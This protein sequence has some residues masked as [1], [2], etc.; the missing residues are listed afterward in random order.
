MIGTPT[1]V[2]T[3]VRFLHPEKGT[4]LLRLGASGADVAE[5]IAR[6]LG[7]SS[8]D[9]AARRASLVELREVAARAILDRPGM[10]R[11]IT[12]LPFAQGDVIVALGDSL[13]ADLLSWAYQLE[14]LLGVVLPGRELRVVNH[15]N[16]GDTTADVIERL[17]LV[18]AERPAWVLQLLGTN[19]ARRHGRGAHRVFTRAAIAGNLAT[20]DAIL[21]T[22][23]SA[24]VVRMTPPPIV[25]ADIA[26]WAEFDQQRISWRADDVRDIRDD[27]VAVDPAAIDLYSAIPESML[28][29]DG[30][31]LA[32]EG[33]QAVAEMLIRTLAGG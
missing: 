19:D 1:R 3:A 30:L 25:E 9:L 18:V 12:A 15:G 29:P 33:Q 21:G 13:T 6:D 4:D 14:Y 7:I 17:D 8:L 20:I 22:E 10:E 5:L 24:R 27:L 16:S 28:G 2:E 26:A 32:L 31:H 23:T 11:A